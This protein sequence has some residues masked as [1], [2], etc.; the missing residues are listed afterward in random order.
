MTTK[1]QFL[2]VLQREL[3]K[4]DWARDDARFAKAMEEV[5]KTLNGQHNCMLSESWVKAWKEIGMKGKPTYKGLH[6][7]PES[8]AA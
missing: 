1:Q 4:H 6:A 3:L 8:E 5:R 2:A 7:L